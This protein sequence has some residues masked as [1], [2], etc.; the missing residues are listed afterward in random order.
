MAKPISKELRAFRKLLSQRGGFLVFMDGWRCAVLAK[1]G[2]K[3][4]SIVFVDGSKQRLSVPQWDA[5][6]KRK[7]VKVGRNYWQAEERGQA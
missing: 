2:R 4:N 1:Q 5:L 7:L 6:P 3:W